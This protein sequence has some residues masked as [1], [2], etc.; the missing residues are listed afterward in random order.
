MATALRWINPWVLAAVG[1]VA[2]AVWAVPLFRRRREFGKVVA[3]INGFDGLLFVAISAILV[4]FEISIL[5]INHDD[6][7]RLYSR[8]MRVFVHGVIIAIGAKIRVK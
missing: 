6:F 8:I 7:V 2:V 1:V 5:Y 4:V 3:L